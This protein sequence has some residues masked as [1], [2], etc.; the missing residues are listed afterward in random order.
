MRDGLA[1]TL[2]AAG[3]RPGSQGHPSPDGPEGF[4]L[5]QSPD[6]PIVIQHATVAGPVGG[7]SPQ[8]RADQMLGGC[9]RK[10]RGAGYDTTRSGPASLTVRG[11]SPSSHPGQGATD[12]GDPEPDN[13]ILANRAAIA[14]SAGYRAGDLERARQLTDQAAALD[15]TR[16]EVWQR[17]RAE[18]DAKRI[19]HEAVAARAEG[20]RARARELIEDAAR[21]NPRMTSLWD[22]DLPGLPGRREPA[23]RDQAGLG[24][25]PSRPTAEPA[26]ARDC[27]NAAEPRWPERPVLHHSHDARLH[28]RGPQAAES[29]DTVGTKGASRAS[30]DRQPRPEPEPETQ[31]DRFQEAAPRAAPPDW[32]DAVTERERREWQPKV[33]AAEP[34]LAAAAEPSGAEISG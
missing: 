11:P 9:A 1:R 33:V 8:D 17:H 27:G 12:H 4:L 25:A 6:G 26:R 13:R 5:Q 10:L 23:A 14:A 31:L 24:D 34:E 29:G 20:D 32:R 30:I 18:I 3:F 19:L 2:R 22:Q 21:L 7:V 15:P 16:A 28:G